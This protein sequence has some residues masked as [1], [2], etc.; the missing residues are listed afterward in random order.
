[1]RIGKFYVHYNLVESGKVAPALAF[2]EFVPLRVEC[3]GYYR[4]YEYI[5]LS[6]LFDETPEGQMAPEYEIIVNDMAEDGKISVG[7]RKLEL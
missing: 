6:P 1:M 2:M 7:V 5:G 4:K 3:I